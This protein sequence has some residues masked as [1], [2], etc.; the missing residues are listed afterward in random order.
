[1]D[2]NAPLKIPAKVRKRLETLVR[3]ESDPMPPDEFRRLVRDARIINAPLDGYSDPAWRT[4]CLRRGAGLGFTEMVPAIALVFGGHDAMKRLTRATDEKVL[5][6]QIEG[7]RPD[8]MVRAAQIAVGAGADV[9][10]INAGCPSPRVTNSGAGSALLSDLPLLAEITT[11]VKNAVR[12]P[13]TMKVRSGPTLT[14]IV[15]DE[16]AALVND[17]DLAAVTLHPRARSQAYRG[18]ADWSLIARFKQLC[19]PPVIGNGDI[20]CAA[21]ALSMFEQTGCD[22][23]MVARGAVGNPW[24]FRDIR[25]ALDG[26]ADRREVSLQEWLDTINEHFDLLVAYLDGDESTAARMFRKHLARYT[27]GLVGGAAFRKGLAVM[28]GRAAMTE[29]LVTLMAQQ[30]GVGGF[31]FKAPGHD[32]TF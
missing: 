17:L 18:V 2:P 10:D 24:L 16:V 6:V 5:A 4:V 22:A 30:D 20:R 32:D 11:A 13:V 25:D 8:I 9:I 12:V 29:A 1:M 3:V 23:V 7:A 31:V 19:R 28:N 26:R 21:D 27:K 14:N 15:V